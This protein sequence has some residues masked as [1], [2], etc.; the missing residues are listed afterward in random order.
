MRVNLLIQFLCAK[1]VAPDVVLSALTL[2]STPTITFTLPILF[3]FN[4]TRTRHPSTLTHLL[5]LN[6]YAKRTHFQSLSLTHPHPPTLFP[7][8]S[9]YCKRLSCPIRLWM[10][11][12]DHETNDWLTGHNR[13]CS[14]TILPIDLYDNNRSK[15]AGPMPHRWI[16]K[17]NGIHI[18]ARSKTDK[19]LSYSFKLVFK[20]LATVVEIKQ[21][22]VLFHSFNLRALSYTWLVEEYRSESR[23]MFVGIWVENIE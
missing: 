18:D 23:V 2:T 3:Y 12:N 22:R 17:Q 14:A 16:A 9:I 5:S 19:W 13:D 20:A 6:P 15:L 8:F 21:K 10:I 7:F 1:H 11:D 4:H